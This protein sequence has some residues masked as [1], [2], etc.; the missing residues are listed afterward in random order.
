M[1]GSDSYFLD[2]DGL[3]GPAI[4]F[5]EFATQQIILIANICT[6]PFEDIRDCQASLD[7]HWFLDSMW[8]YPRARMLVEK[9]DGPLGAERQRPVVPTGSLLTPLFKDLPCLLAILR[10]RLT[11]S[12]FDWRA[13]NYM[14]LS[15]TASWRDFARNSI[16]PGTR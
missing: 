15:A 3:A 7:G 11:A 16:S 8:N 1:R 6:K 5:F 14:A 4:A 10:G 2:P 9:F 13:P 12:G